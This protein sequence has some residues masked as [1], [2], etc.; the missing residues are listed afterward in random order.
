MAYHLGGKM[1][2]IVLARFEPGEDL[3]LGLRSV[4]KERGIR[5]GVIL[6]C[7][8]S[9]VRARLQKFLKTG[10]IDRTPVGIVEIEGPLEASG[11]G[12]I[13]QTRGAGGLGEYVDGEPYIHAHIT[14]TSSEGTF[15]GHLMPGT[16]VRS[17]REISHFTVVLASFD[18]VVL[19]R[20]GDPSATVRDEKGQVI[21]GG[22]YHE[23]TPA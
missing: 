22:G 21:S 4:I 8:G 13:G 12:L 23:L 7:T 9:L 18:G 2:E 6:D 16:I 5:T 1:G 3:L 15:C 19:T 11:H 17:N 14:V 20:V 10:A